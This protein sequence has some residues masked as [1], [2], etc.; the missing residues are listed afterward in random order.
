V[1][2]HYD[3]SMLNSSCKN[4]L[5]TATKRVRVVTPLSNME[6]QITGHKWK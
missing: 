4:K 2:S 3:E 6:S 1:G 5:Q